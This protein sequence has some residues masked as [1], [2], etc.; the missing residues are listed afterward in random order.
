VIGGVTTVRHIPKSALLAL[1]FVLGGW[2]VPASAQ[3]AEI[4]RTVRAGGTVLLTNSTV[5][6][7]GTCIS[8]AADADPRPAPKLGRLETRVQ[9]GRTPTCKDVL[10]RTIVYRAGKKRGTDKFTLYIVTD[11][12]FWDTPVTIHVR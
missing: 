4:V 1:A 9:R 7:Q 6:E 12:E 10:Y 2:I 3:V 11:G 8:T 5:I